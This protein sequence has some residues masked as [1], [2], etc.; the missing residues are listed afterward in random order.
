MFRPAMVS[1]AGTCAHRNPSRIA[2]VVDSCCKS[3][4]GIAADDQLKEPAGGR[5]GHAGREHHG[6]ALADRKRPEANARAADGRRAA[7]RAVRE[8]SA[9]ALRR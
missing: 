4:D 6:S 7:L 1:S 9:A 8:T 3:R 5:L 2:I